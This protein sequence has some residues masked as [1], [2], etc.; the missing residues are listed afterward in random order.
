MMLFFAT[1]F[2]SLAHAGAPEPHPEPFT[3]ASL[4]GRWYAVG[5]PEQCEAG[6][7]IFLQGRSEEEAHYINTAGRFGPVEARVYQ[8]PGSGFGAMMEAK[9]GEDY[10]GFVLEHEHK[11]ATGDLI[12]APIMPTKEEKKAKADGFYDLVKC[13]GDWPE[14]KAPPASVVL[15]TDG[16]AKDP[17]GLGWLTGTWG[18]TALDGAPATGMFAVTCDKLSGLEE[19]AEPAAPIPNM[20]LSSA[21]NRYTFKGGL[22]LAARS[23]GTL[24]SYASMW[25]T[26]GFFGIAEP[27]D[28]SPKLQNGTLYVTVP[29][30]ENLVVRKIDNDH[31]LWL[32]PSTATSMGA[33]YKAFERCGDW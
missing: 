29:T 8:L 30:G 22:A 16:S 33:P 10:R 23:D 32:E 18:E 13:T 31:M 20:S 1:L 7:H 24:F 25:G 21:S 6:T 9:Y 14:T 28:L 3:A 12:I 11:R 5:H 26:G 2:G 27:I 15:P 17:K 4:A 19:G